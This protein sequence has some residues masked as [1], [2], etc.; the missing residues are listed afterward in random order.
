MNQDEILIQ[1]RNRVDSAMQS[2]LL[3]TRE[4]VCEL[5]KPLAAQGRFSMENIPADSRGNLG[6]VD[7]IARTMDPTALLAVLL[8]C[9]SDR[10]GPALLEIPGV[11][12]Q[13][14]DKVR[15]IRNDH[16]H[17][18]GDFSD[19]NY[20][21]DAVN[22]VNDLKFGLLGAGPRPSTPVTTTPRPSTPLPTRPRSATPRVEIYRHPTMPLP[23]TPR[24]E[25]NPGL[26]AS[27]SAAAAAEEKPVNAL[28]LR[29]QAEARIRRVEGVLRP[30][31]TQ[32]FFDA[33][34][35]DDIQVALRLVQEGIDTTTVNSDGLAPLH[36]ASSGNNL[37]GLVRD[38]I[39]AGADIHAQDND[40]NTPLH[41][42]T[43]LGRLTTVTTLIGALGGGNLVDARNS[44]GQTPLHLAAANGQ[45]SIIDT[46]LRARS[47]LNA[48][49]NSGNTPLHLA[50]LNKSEE[51]KGV[52]LQAGADL[53][54]SNNAGRTPPQLAAYVRLTTIGRWVLFSGLVCLAAIAAAVLLFMTL[55]GA[56]LETAVLNNE[57]WK[58]KALAAVGVDVNT[59]NDDTYRFTPLHIA[60]RHDQSE[61]AR[62]LISAGAEV[63]SITSIDG[64]PL[65][66]A[67]FYGSVL[68]GKELVVAGADIT[69]RTEDGYTPL[70][71]AAINKQVGTGKQLIEAGT[72]YN[73]GG[74]RSGRAPL[75]I[76]AGNG[77][78]SFV[79]IL[80]DA[81]A[82]VNAGDLRGLT[83]LHYAIWRP[84]MGIG[85]FQG[86]RNIESGTEMVNLLVSLGSDVGA[87]SNIG[88]APLHMAA[89]EGDIEII[90]ALIR[91][92]A[93]VNDRN[94]EGITALVVAE[95]SNHAAAAAIIVEGGGTR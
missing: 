44:Q 49:E 11:N 94:D 18:E 53:S 62:A 26:K 78:I 3:D 75:H 24:V 90:N 38:L 39:S 76:A 4:I 60:A 77:D 92:G 36:L 67:A 7:D 14:V 31:R 73:A 10:S 17:G 29:R 93:D 21:R 34:S 33:Y 40:G 81:G 57:V 91:A 82:D 13:L 87:R 64:T 43:S 15:R 9:L 42:T 71:V 20:V 74:G 19:F 69:A 85:Y 48:Q 66:E 32:A 45:T 51:M 6:T 54:V 46:L 30:K 95:E 61:A 72:D 2:F 63:N 52:L 25:D 1:N 27:E 65:H 50:M 5:V 22:A 68:T 86:E 88:S 41:L 16:A 83:P 59:P 80:A 89:R 23:S 58:V 35:R 56:V 79:R 37:A 84:Q 70:A 55:G 28:T 47:D 12:F 8:G